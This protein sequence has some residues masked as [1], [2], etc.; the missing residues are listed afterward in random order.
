MFVIEQTVKRHSVIVPAVLDT[1]DK[2]ECAGWQFEVVD[3]DGK[4]IDK[5]LA[6]AITDQ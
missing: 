3:L 1:T 5:V 2:V 6:S 4:R